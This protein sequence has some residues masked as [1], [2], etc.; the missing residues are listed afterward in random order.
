MNSR[1]NA[2]FYEENL[3]S[4]LRVAAIVVPWLLEQFPAQSVVDVGCSYGAW[5][6]AFA[7]RGAARIQGLDGPWVGRDQLRIPEQNFLCVDLEQPLPEL[8]EFDLAVSLEVA[9]HLSPQ[10]AD[11]LITDLCNLAPLVAFSAAIPGQG[12]VHHINE[13]WPSYWWERF[14]ARGYRLA[15]PRPVFWNRPD[16]NICYRQNLLLY[17]SNDAFHR[18][19]RLNDWAWPEDMPPLPL[20]DPE[21]YLGFVHPPLRRWL[22]SA[23]PAC[24]GAFQHRVFGRAASTLESSLVQLRSGSGRPRGTAAGDRRFQASRGA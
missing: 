2:A 18:W 22:S 17:G 15:D 11:G 20:V 5:L 6:A 12:G 4:G 10:R 3:N 7:E 1:Y 16:L 13:Q 24:W 9:E 23:W 21:L 14:R 19:P 8:G